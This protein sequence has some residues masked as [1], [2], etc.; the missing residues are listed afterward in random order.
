MIFPN[1]HLPPHVHVFKGGAEVRIELVDEPIVL[2]VEGGIG[3]KDLVK[4]L[5]L[6]VDRQC[7]FLEK[8]R[9]IHE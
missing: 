8:W 3:N 9:E 6:V 2:S 5:N 7:E 4:A 1:D